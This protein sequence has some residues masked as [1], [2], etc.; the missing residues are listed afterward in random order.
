MSCRWSIPRRPPWWYGYS[1]PPQTRHGRGTCAASYGR[2]IVVVVRVLWLVPMTALARRRDPSIDEQV[3]ADWRDTLIISWAGVR[4]VVTVASALALPRTT[5]T[6]APFPGRDQIVFVAVMVVLTTLIVQGTS[7]RWLIDWLNV[8]VDPAAQHEA[9]LRVSRIALDAA[10]AQLEELKAAG[11]VDD[12]IAE[13]AA[14]ACRALLADTFFDDE[15]AAAADESLLHKQIRAV[16]REIL[17]AARTAAIG[18]RAEH[19]VDPD[20]ADR[21]IH[22]LDL[23]TLAVE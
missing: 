7:L 14:D 19:A 6:G 16:E 2:V 23:R 11:V 22:R 17:R 3:P 1:H 5:A 21:L 13:H 8:R 9:E 15:E 18:A 10:L 4:G 12:Q 20:A